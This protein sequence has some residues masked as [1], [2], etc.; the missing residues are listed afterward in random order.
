VRFRDKILKPRHHDEANAQGAVLVHILK[1]FVE[2]TLCLTATV[3]QAAGFR[4]IE[5]PADAG[6]PALA[7]GI[8][9]PCPEP[10]GSIE[11]AGV[12]I[13]GA[14]GCLLSGD[15]LPLVVLSHGVGGSFWNLHNIAAAMADGGF[16]VA[17]ITH[18][19]LS[20][21]SEPSTAGSPAWMVERPNDIRRLITFALGES[22]AAP[23]IDRNR[24]GFYGF[25]AGGYTGLVLIGAEPDWTDASVICKHYALAGNLC[26]E[27]SGKL[28]PA[29]PPAN[30][31]R[32][33][34]AVLAD[35]GPAFFNAESF[36][37][38]TVPIQ[39]WASEGGGPR[40]QVDAIDKVLRAAHEYRV[41][42]KSRYAAGRGHFAFI[43][44]PP[45]LV[46]RRPDVCIDAPGFDRTAFL[47]QFN[48]DVLA[49]FRTH[50]ADR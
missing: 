15:K 12:T 24:I 49:F 2:V 6:N 19:D 3:A 4:F 44:C 22:F 14:K 32:I 46:E 28:L 20:R 30:E 42:A 18:P 10:P 50:F 36:A 8:W 21:R 13:A 7:G 26:G 47:R 1:F 41:V 43:S 11:V 40:D 31:P 5:V 27:V 25:S 29:G 34:A 23:N 38:I 9:Y 37:A 16:V 35:P 33:K 39:L 17:A 45:Q 48:A